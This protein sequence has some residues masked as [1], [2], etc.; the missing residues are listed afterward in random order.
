[1]FSQLRC[2]IFDRDNY[3]VEG[4]SECGETVGDNAYGGVDAALYLD[5]AG[6]GFTL[7]DN[8]GDLDPEVCR[9]SSGDEKVAVLDLS[10]CNLTGL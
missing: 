8:I 9:Y 1:M 2:W 5:N 4:R 7:P 6:P 10:E 3:N